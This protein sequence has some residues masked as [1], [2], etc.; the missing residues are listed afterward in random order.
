[1]KKTSRNM[2]D[3]GVQDSL[4]IMIFVFVFSRPI[5]VCLKKNKASLIICELD[6]HSANSEFQDLL[7]S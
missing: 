1:M 2:H 3:Q 6:R 7:L 5:Q 4:N